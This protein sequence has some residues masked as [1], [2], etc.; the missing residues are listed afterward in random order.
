MHSDGVEE[1][2]DKAGNPFGRSRIQG[3]FLAQSQTPL[4]T[5]LWAILRA[6]SMH[7]AGAEEDGDDFTLMGLEVLAETT[8]QVTAP[9]AEAMPKQAE[10]TPVVVS[11]QET[12]T[13]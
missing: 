4:A 11:S 3:L 8:S 5:A 2:R 13:Q 6:H 12:A 7:V 1:G 10:P 9:L